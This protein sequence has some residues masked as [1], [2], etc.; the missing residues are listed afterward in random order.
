[1]KVYKLTPKRLRKIL[2]IS[3]KEIAKILECR[4]ESVYYA[5][6]S[7]GKSELKKRIEELV[8]IKERAVK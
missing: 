3:I 4:R 1:L 5:L 6:S 8:I 7:K 2:G